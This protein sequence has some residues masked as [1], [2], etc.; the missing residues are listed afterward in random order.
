M[1]PRNEGQQHRD[2]KLRG[3]LLPV[4][5]LPSGTGVGCF[6]AQAYEFV[7]FLA[8]A[9]QNAWQIL[10][11]GPVDQWYSPYQ[12][13]STCAG[14]PLYIDPEKLVQEG[15]LTEEELDDYCR[16][17]RADGEKVRY[18][19]VIPAKEKLLRAAYARVS[20]SR[21][22][23]APDTSGDQ[24]YLRRF[25]EFCEEHGDWLDDYCLF[26]AL[27][28][29]HGGKPWT[30][31]ETAC[32]SREPEALEKARGY[33]RES[34]DYYAWQ[35]YEFFRQWNAL[36]GYAGEQGIQIIGDMPYYVT[37]DSVECWKDPS[38]FQLDGNNSPTFISGAPGDGF[39]R[40]G[41]VWNSPVYDWASKEETLI[42]WWRERIRHGF[43]FYDIIRL[44]HVRAFTAYYAIPADRPQARYGSWQKGPGAAVFEPLKE[45]ISH[46]RLIAEDLGVITAD[47]RGMMREAKLPGMAVLQF[48]FDSG[49]KNPYRP[50]NIREG[51]VVYTGT[52][53]NDTT[54]GWYRSLKRL[55]RWR[56]NRFCRAQ[57]QAM[58]GSDCTDI[59]RRSG[60]SGAE[61]VT[62]MLVRAALRS[63]GSI[64]MIPLQD[65]LALGSEARINTPGTTGDNWCWRVDK[66]VLTEST[67]ERI[68]NIVTE[69]QI[70]S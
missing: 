14:E 23:M 58:R 18:E 41:Q 31:W 70:T 34:M 29:H 11:L 65:Y 43:E 67:A 20:V 15:L 17:I 40:R 9:G 33:L 46:G 59:K 8:A 35:Q 66:A 39:D 32:A 44:D 49:K 53:D 55:R 4:F 64:V 54:A 69:E 68:R 50:D 22:R 47:V 2:H 63:R 37:L 42:S 13:C 62:D 48:A 25:D 51:T 27:R 26:M 38:L 45:E 52:H 16:E 3:I 36:R 1:I 12:P 57:E 24:G 30:E 56:V 10:P 28:E 7:D 60:D 61:R 19:Q 5:S 6:S 21:K